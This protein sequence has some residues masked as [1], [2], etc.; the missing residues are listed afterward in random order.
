MELFLI[1]AFPAS[2]HGGSGGGQSVAASNRS[3]CGVSNS[4]ELNGE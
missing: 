4:E 2:L 1:W 3:K